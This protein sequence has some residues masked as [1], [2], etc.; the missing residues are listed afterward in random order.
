[1]VLAVLAVVRLAEAVVEADVLGIREERTDKEPLQVQCSKM[2][3]IHW[4]RYNI[5]ICRRGISSQTCDD[6]LSFP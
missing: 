1:M 6:G 3:V 5:N 2:G 4:K